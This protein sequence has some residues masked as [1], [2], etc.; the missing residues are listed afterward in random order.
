VETNSTGVQG[1]RR[2][3]A[4][5]D[6][7]LSAD[8]CDS[9]V[10]LQQPQIRLITCLS[11]YLNNELRCYKTTTWQIIYVSTKLLNR[12]LSESHNEINAPRCAVMAGSYEGDERRVL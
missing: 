1:S 3:V 5:S 8:W 2:A 11:N 7:D 4:P 12:V 9:S 6:D 10:A